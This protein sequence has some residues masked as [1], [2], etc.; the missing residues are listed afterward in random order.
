M[1]LIFFYIFH[2][3]LRVVSQIQYKEIECIFQSSDRFDFSNEKCTEF[4][5]IE[6]VEL[7][8]IFDKNIKYFS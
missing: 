6:F 7:L 4:F 2:Q 5:C 3:K 8:L 1:F